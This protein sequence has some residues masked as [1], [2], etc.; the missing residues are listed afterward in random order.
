MSASQQT[1]QWLTPGGVSVWASYDS[2]DGQAFLD[3]LVESIDARRGMVLTSGV[4]TPGRYTRADIGFVDP[5][6]AVTASGPVL[7][8]EALNDRGLPL[9]HAF[10]DALGTGTQVSSHKVTWPIPATEHLTAEEE[11]TRQPSVFTALRAF[12]SAMGYPGDSA[13]GLYGA[14]GYDLVLAFE[15]VAH[16]LRR[17]PGKRDVVL[18]VP[19]QVLY[20]DRARGT[21]KLSSYEF[22]YQQ[23]SS[24]GHDRLTESSPY[25]GAAS[26]AVSRDHEAGEYSALV[27]VAKQYFARGDLFEVVPGQVFFEPCAQTPG[28][29]FRTLARRDPAP[30]GFF[31]NL[32]GQEYLV[33]ASPEMYVRVEP[34]TAPDGSVRLR[35]ETCPISG[36]IARG[37]DALEDAHQIRTLLGSIK[38]ESELTMCTD[39]DRNDKARVCE[40]GSIHVIGRRQIELYARLIHTVDHVEGI[41]RP[42]RDALD[43]F[44]THAWAVTVTGAPKR[45]AIE[46]IEQ[47]EKSPRRWYGGA[48]GH[49]GFDGRLNTGLTLRTI[50]IENGVAAVR[51]GATLLHDSDPA[52]EEAETELKASS[53]LDAIRTAGGTSIRR[54]LSTVDYSPGKGRRVLLVDHQDSFVHML[55]DYFRQ[56]GAEVVT[57]RAGFPASLLAE[58]KPDLVVLSPGPGRPKDFDLDRTLRLSLE[59][60]LPI[61]GVCLGLQGIAE[62]FGG[63]LGQ[64]EIPMHG[65]AS[66]VRLTGDGGMVLA[67]LPETFQVGRYHSLYADISTLPSELRVTASTDDGVIMALEHES[68]P[69]SAV[70]FHPE[71]IMSAG[72]SLGLQIVRQAVARLRA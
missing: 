27:D 37:R 72:Q 66:T 18:F 28:A 29:V 17:D 38:D 33:G 14:F 51:A 26:P 49:C 45:A 42:D 16:K 67:G 61:F 48:V 30:F 25:Q 11:R 12:I 68:L 22:E 46:F 3:H 56:C 4:D 65:K 53:M 6:L 41:L 2:V 54:D 21:A 62:Y 24:R 58:L 71:S 10:A 23:W 59:Q 13:L 35:A 44:L 9:L 34:Q 57:Y 5:P 40:P 7:T 63:T 39:V 32:G 43:A 36:T 64:L 20:I 69:I 50:H 8:L 60:Q 70:Q 19:D 31:A 1:R 47:H 55:G 15:N 52:A